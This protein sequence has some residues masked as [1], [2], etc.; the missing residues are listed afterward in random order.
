MHDVIMT[1]NVTCSDHMSDHVFMN[2]YIVF[3]NAIT[4]IV[5]RVYSYYSSW[6][7]TADDYCYRV[8]NYSSWSLTLLT[9]GK[10]S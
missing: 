9:V 2:A 1:A 7:Q 4:C 6:S 10:F 8:V 5:Y 3:M